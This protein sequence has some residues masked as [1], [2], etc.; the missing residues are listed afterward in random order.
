MIGAYREI[1]PADPED[2]TH[3]GRDRR[4]DVHLLHESVGAGVP[5]SLR[6]FTELELYGV[7]CASE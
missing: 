1:P 5:V 6:T 4:D 7:A 3:H 2:G